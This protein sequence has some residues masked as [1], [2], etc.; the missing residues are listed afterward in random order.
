[1]AQGAVR[2]KLVVIDPPRLDLAPRVVDG[3]ELIGVQTFVAQFSVERLDIAVIYRLSGS[4]EIQRNAAL[5]PQMP[6]LIL[7]MLGKISICLAMDEVCSFQR[8]RTGWYSSHPCL[9][10][11]Q[12]C[13]SRRRR[14]R[15]VYGVGL[16]LQ[17]SSGPVRWWVQSACSHVYDDSTLSMVF[18]AL[19][20]TAGKDRAIT[21][22]SRSPRPHAV[23]SNLPLR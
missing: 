1:M 21:G 5:V 14:S 13:G 20:P 19:M 12:P 4:N 2:P 16:F 18:G 10:C 23:I 11:N 15:S 22:T 6:A 7:I 17:T 8:S 9:S 3:Q